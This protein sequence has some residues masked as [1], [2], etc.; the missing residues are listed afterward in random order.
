MVHVPLLNLRELT[1]SSGTEFESGIYQDEQRQPGPNMDHRDAVH[2][3]FDMGTCC[4]PSPQHG[5]DPKC[6]RIW[7]AASNPC[8]HV[9]LFTAGSPACLYEFLCLHRPLLAPPF[10]P[11]TS[12]LVY[13][14]S[15][16][17]SQAHGVLQATL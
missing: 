8:G 15:T 7:G 14:R 12:H 9:A 17:L 4:E 5:P 10:S 13:A 11:I 1:L 6:W 3:H 16:P 2:T